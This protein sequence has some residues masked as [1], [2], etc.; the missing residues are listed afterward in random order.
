MSSISQQFNTDG[1][2]LCRSLF[3]ADEMQDLKMHCVELL[4]EENLSGVD[5]FPA[6]TCTENLRAISCDQRFVKILKEIIGP[7]VDFLSV[8]TVI[9]SSKTSFPSPWH[10]DQLYWGG[11]TKISA[12]LAIDDATI[13]NGC[14]K[15]VPGSHLQLQ[16]HSQAESGTAF[17][18]RVPDE[19]VET[20]NQIDVEMKQGDILIFHDMLLHSS[21]P[22]ESGMDRWS[23][24]PT[25]R[26]RT[27]EDDSSLNENTWKNPVE[28]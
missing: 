22:N 5:V 6:D 19:Q 12:W 8:K 23:L 20:M 28:I 27:L 17:P 2:Y 15:I 1:F 14:L 4:I 24:I 18:I 3:T 16:T 7:Q 25:Y 26:D 13:S 21:Y 10:Q 11:T 9:K